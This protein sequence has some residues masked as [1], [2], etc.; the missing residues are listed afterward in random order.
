M[1]IGHRNPRPGCGRNA[2]S[3]GFITH[4][5]DGEASVWVADLEFGF[6]VAELRHTRCKAV[7]NDGDVSIFGYLKWGRVAAGT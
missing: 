4:V 2:G 6:K 1:R 5:A 3:V 7:T